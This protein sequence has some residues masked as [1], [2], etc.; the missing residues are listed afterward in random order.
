MT[1]RKGDEPP[2]VPLTPMTGADRQHDGAMGSRCVRRLAVRRILL[3]R[4]GL[5]LQSFLDQIFSRCALSLA[6]RPR[7]HPRRIQLPACIDQGPGAQVAP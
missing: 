6:L 7:S 2:E 1:D 4:T 3:V 5:S